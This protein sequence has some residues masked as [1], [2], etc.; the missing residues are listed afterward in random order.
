MYIKSKFLLTQA[1]AGRWS[2]AAAGAQA[3]DP[4]QRLANG[5]LRLAVGELSVGNY[6]L[7]MG[8]INEG[9]A[10]NHGNHNEIMALL[11][12][13]NI[14]VRLRLKCE[15][16]GQLIGPTCKSAALPYSFTVEMLDV[17]QKV[18]R[19]RNH[20]EVLRISHHA[21][22]SEVKR[23][24]KRLALRLH[25]DKNRAPGADIAF[26]RINEAADTLTDNQKRIEYNLLT[27]V[28]DCFGG[29]ASLYGKDV[30]TAGVQYEPHREQQ[31]DEEQQGDQPRRSYQPANQRVPQRQSLYQTEQLVIGLVAALVFIIITVHYL[32]TAP[33]YSFTPTS[34]HSVRLVSRLWRVPY[35]VTPKLAASQTPKQLERME[36]EIEEIY[37]TEIKHNCKQERKLRDKLLQR[38]RNTN[39]HNLLDH[40]LKMPTPACHALIKLDQFKSQPLLLDNISDKNDSW[41]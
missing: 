10:R 26:R 3:M 4:D 1:A 18:L 32:S 38:A 37:L 7:A 19:C 34:S 15:T 39:N 12:L 27:A 24:Y 31:P 11:E 17:V 16:P 29:K 36:S 21:T 33:N 8:L 30:K 9:M 5:C 13:K 20:Y 28:G 25:P 14:V 35:F 41:D 6:T 40:A 23:A 2:S 22:Y